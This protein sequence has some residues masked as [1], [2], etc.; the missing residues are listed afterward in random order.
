[1]T[2]N[3]NELTIENSALLL[4]GPGATALTLTPRGLDSAAHA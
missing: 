2:K 4:I 3:P 1:M